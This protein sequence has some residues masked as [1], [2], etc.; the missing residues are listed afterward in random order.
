MF[1]FVMALLVMH[2]L[3]YGFSDGFRWY[4]DSKQTSHLWTS[5][6]DQSIFSSS[7]LHIQ[8]LFWMRAQQNTP[9]RFTSTL[10][11]GRNTVV[12][13]NAKP[14]QERTNSRWLSDTWVRSCPNYTWFKKNK[15]TLHHHR[16]T[17]FYHHQNPQI[18]HTVAWLWDKKAYLFKACDSHTNLT[19]APNTLKLPL[20]VLICN[21]LS[22]RFSSGNT[23]HKNDWEWGQKTTS[24]LNL[25]S[26]EQ[27]TSEMFSKVIL[28][29]MI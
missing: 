25:N 1:F 13:L 2:W 22:L 18:R 5:M 14:S 20:F 28:K 6:F 9:D 10:V 21:A 7:P 11:L 23:I 12:Y 4:H 3:V 17:E 24:V 29:D 15:Q 16:H 8:K 27:E 26:C 19:S